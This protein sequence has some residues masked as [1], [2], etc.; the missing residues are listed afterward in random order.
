MTFAPYTNLQAT[1]DFARFQFDSPTLPEPITRQVSLTGHQNGRI[2]HVDLRNRPAGKSDDPSWPDSKDFLCVVVTVIQII[3]VYSE[4]YPRRALR[5]SG[6][7][8]LKALVFG[9]MLTR[10]Q[11]LLCPLFQIDTERPGTMG[12]EDDVRAYAFLLRRKPIPFFSVHTVESTW[13]GTS[14]IFNT[15]F[16]IGLD[17]SI[18]VGLT[19]PTM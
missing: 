3:E 5:F 10:F 13:S 15:G 12:P 6:D 19:L 4:R 11:H 17:K 18:R 2:Y 16:S 8:P 7:T 14:R 1:T 9:M